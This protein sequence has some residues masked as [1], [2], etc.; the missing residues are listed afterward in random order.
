MGAHCFV[1]L[2]LMQLFL[3]KQ[4]SVVEQPLSIL[5]QFYTQ[6]KQQN[7]PI[8]HPLPTDVVFMHNKMS[9]KSPFLSLLSANKSSGCPQ[10]KVFSISNETHLR[11]FQVLSLIRSNF[12]LLEC[13][14][15]G[16]L[17]FQQC[18]R[19]LKSI[20][21]LS[22]I[23]KLVARRIFAM[24][25]VYE[26]KHK[27]NKSISS[28]LKNALFQQTKTHAL[29]ISFQSVGK[30]NEIVF[31][32]ITFV[33]PLEN[34]CTIKRSFLTLSKISVSLLFRWLLARDENGKVINC[35]FKNKKLNAV[36]TQVR[37]II[38]LKKL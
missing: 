5:C 24:L 19:I 30:E 18:L 6:I 15:D 29:I 13:S 16:K 7:R 8:E 14:A 28:Q 21:E 38:K 12:L 33:R 27:T 31:N 11:H 32:H 35:D 20:S 23:D 4:L 36:V 2:L 3:C 25:L 37:T 10:I 26:E 22:L 34:V 17:G 9:T 1:F